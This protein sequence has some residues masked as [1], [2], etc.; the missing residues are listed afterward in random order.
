MKRKEI[1]KMKRSYRGWIK[2]RGIF[3][4]KDTKIY[5][6]KTKWGVYLDIDIQFGESL[7]IMVHC[8][9]ACVHFHLHF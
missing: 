2:K 7:R 5:L 8:V 6:K 1:E 9:S 3:G 4:V